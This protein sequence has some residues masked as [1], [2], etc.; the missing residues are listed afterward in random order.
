MSFTEAEKQDRHR[1]IQQVLLE[2]KLQAIV[3]IGDN[4][5]GHGF[6]G[7]FRY[8][9]NNRTFFQRQIAVAFPDSEP[10]L[11]TYSGFSGRAARERSFIHDVRI[12]SGYSV[13]EGVKQIDPLFI[14]VIELLRER[15]IDQGKIGINFEMLPFA[16]YTYFKKELPDLE[17]VDVHEN[18]MR[19]RLKRTKEEAEIFRRG[20]ALADA[21]F[22]AALEVIRP[23]ISEYE[24]IAEIE[25]AARKKGAEEFFTLIGS[26][27]FAFGEENALG[28]P[29]T[30]SGR[31]IEIGDSIILEIT[32]RYEG[33]WTQL[34]R[35][36]NVGQ[37]N[38]DLEKMQSV[39]RDAIKE[40]LKE[41]KPG[42]KVKDITR[43][44]ESY[45]SSCGF[46]GK[47]PFGHICGIDL[48]EERV[49]TKNDR[50]F[51]PGLAV[52]IHPMVYTADGKTVIFWG[53]TYMAT[54]EGYERLHHTDD[55][56][57]TVK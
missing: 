9:T 3:F 22:Q 35:I 31:V 16:G 5:I 50:E 21:G 55:T 14:D 46:I 37:P 53:E 15:S 29:V 7:D 40:G 51:Q 13:Y 19:I 56:L 39:C 33:Y 48:V 2:N 1:A 42:K 6:L 43:T 34:V 23:G 32:P 38:S 28:L 27:K 11:F 20:A 47:P 30:P 26:G 12:S 57:V 4:N 44:M 49:H 36:V 24:I 8:Y 17:L 10:V 41:F 18:I 52:I 25:Y 45:I 54:S